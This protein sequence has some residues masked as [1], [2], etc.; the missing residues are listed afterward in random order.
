[1]DLS[2]TYMGLRLSNPF[3]AGASPLPDDLDVARQLEDAGAAAIVLRSLFEEQVEHD[4][5][6]AE[7]IADK[8]LERL[9]KT[10]E[11][12]NIPVIGS[13]NGHT[14]GGWVRF[15]KLIEEA[16]AT[17]L[18]LNVYHIT[19]ELDLSASDVEQTTLH[20]VQDIRAA[21]NIPLAIKLSPFY[22]SLPHFARQLV[23]AGV[24]GIVLFN[25]FYEPDIDPEDL[26]IER[27]LTLS[28][29]TSL[30]LRLRWLAILSERVGASLAVTGGVHTGLDAV[31]ASL[32]GAHAVQV[33]SALLLQGPDHL[34]Q[35]QA[36]MAE[37]LERR[38]YRSLE[39]AQGRMN[40]IRCGAPR[41]YERAN[42]MDILHAWE[43]AQ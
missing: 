39:Q 24:D 9:A 38:G 40:L 36:E 14:H 25:R 12:L 13:L 20:V 5:K 8:Y 32:V 29:S 16:G 34:R 4:K 7:G 10:R 23:G 6:R 15:A 2:T 41:G 35:M 19:T 42:Y 37:W 11:A 31:K 1:M 30:S 26:T 28:D 27:K 43:E 18:E 22:T 21:A 17:A 33:V 3:L